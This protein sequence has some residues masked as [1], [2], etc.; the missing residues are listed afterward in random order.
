MNLLNQKG[1]FMGAG[2]GQSSIG[3]ACNEPRHEPRLPTVDAFGNSR[4]EDRLWSVLHY[5]RLA[6]IVLCLV[7]LALAGCFRLLVEEIWQAKLVN[8]RLRSNCLIFSRNGLNK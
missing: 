4:N 1:S 6:T 8:S 7:L 2:K 3:I 5:C